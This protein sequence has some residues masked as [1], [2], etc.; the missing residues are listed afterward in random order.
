MPVH[1][2]T[3][4]KGCYAQWGKHGAKYYYKCD[5]KEARKNARHK[6][7]VQGGVIQKSQRMRGEKVSE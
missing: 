1:T 4:K 5:S 3:D 2:G 6:A 7:H